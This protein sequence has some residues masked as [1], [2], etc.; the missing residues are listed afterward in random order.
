[1]WHMAKEDQ[2]HLEQRLA[3]PRRSGPGLDL[4]RS[5]MKV[6]EVEEQGVGERSIL[7]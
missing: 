1:M 3:C 7:S 2:E 5:T 6:I 4:E